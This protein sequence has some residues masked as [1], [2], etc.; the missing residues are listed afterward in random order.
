MSMSQLAIGVT[1][2]VGLATLALQTVLPDPAP[3]EVQSLVYDQGQVLQERTI[4]TKQDAF[5]IA[6]TATV[7]NAETG[8]S[9]RWCEGSGAN[10]YPPGHRVVE[11]RNLAE[12]TGRAECTVDSLPPGT[13]SLRATWR[14]GENNSVSKKS[15][16]FEVTQ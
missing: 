16:V 12:W 6:W 11:F 7:E 8:D 3:I 15:N 5:P 2:A 14:W 4:Y 13:Y 10:G 9:V 1:A